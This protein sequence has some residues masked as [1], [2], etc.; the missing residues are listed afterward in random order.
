MVTTLTT[1]M[2]AGTAQCSVQPYTS[3]DG[4]L[5]VLTRLRLTRCPERLPVL[6]GDRRMPVVCLTPR[7]CRLPRPCLSTDPP[8][9]PLPFVE[10]QHPSRSCSS[11]SVTCFAVWASCN[12]QLMAH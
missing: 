1:P 2:Q 10:P 12:F 5:R 4:E 9:P 8:L 11:C 6:D 7:V 3:F